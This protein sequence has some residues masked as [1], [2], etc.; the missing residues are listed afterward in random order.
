MAR[1]PRLTIVIPTFERPHYLRECLATIEA[2]T[3]R[4]FRVVVLDNAST[5]RY[6]AALARFASLP[7]VYRRNDSNIGASHNIAKA[8]DDHRQSE[9]LVVF[10]DDDLMHP[11]MLEWEMKVLDEH[12]EL[13]FVGSEYELFVDGGAPPMEAWPD[14]DAAVGICDGAAALARVLLGGTE[15]CF[16]SVMYRSTALDGVSMDFARFNMYWDRPF[17]LDIAK[18]GGCAV[19]RAPLVLY[20]HHAAQDSRSDVLSNE[21]LLELMKAYREVL[22]VDDRAEDRLLLLRRSASFLV[23]SYALLSEAQRPSLLAFLRGGLSNDLLR[24]RDLSAGDW[25]AL[26]RGAGHAWV[27]RAAAAARSALRSARSWTMEKCR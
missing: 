10:H 24:L 20:R 12:P 22:P 26:F 3:Y 6:T 15:V 21:N 13:Q 16:G 8:F 2:Q 17:L 1:E 11:R 7:L 4:D 19:I 14:V 18:R 5:T 27:P 25:A 9:F 23:A